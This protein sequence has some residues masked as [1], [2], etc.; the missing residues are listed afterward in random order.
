MP[1]KKPRAKRYPPIPASLDLPGGPVPVT[2]CTRK[3]M[4]KWADPGEELWGYFHEGER[5]ISVLGTLSREAQHR[6]LW[7]EWTHAML[8]DSGLANGLNHELEEALC[9]AVSSALMRVIHHKG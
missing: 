8:Q 1:T 5:R 9:D 6:V 2:V 7:H 4:E 3:E